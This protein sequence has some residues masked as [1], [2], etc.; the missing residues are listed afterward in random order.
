MTDSISYG[1]LAGTYHQLRGGDQRS[2]SI[3]AGVLHIV[4][5]RGRMLD[6]GTGPATVANLLS[7]SGWQLVGV[8][9]S[10]EMIRQAAPHP[11]SRFVVA[12]AACLPFVPSIFDVVLFVWVLHLV[13]D[14]KG[15]LMEAK[16][17]LAKG[18]RIVSVAGLPEPMDDDLDPIR[19][20]MTEQLDA[21]RFHRSERLAGIAASVGL[22]TER[23]GMIELV[24]EL[25]P[26]ELADQIL[27]RQFSVLWNIDDARFAQ[28]VQPA[29][30]HLLS[31]P[32]PEKRRQRLARHRVLVLTPDT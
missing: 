28:I 11:E 3:A 19:R 6:V 27:Q 5:T 29:I 18:G 2:K 7:T 14:V 8:D 4:G 15:S 31:L 25:S 10:I 26:A 22:R 17:M 23:L 12:D 24:S 21:E 13:G 9:V 16:R 1:Q 20:A 30:D 32:E